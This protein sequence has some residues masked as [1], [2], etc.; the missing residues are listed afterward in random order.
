MVQREKC[1]EQKMQIN[2]LHKPTSQKRRLSSRLFLM[3]VTKLRRRG[4]FI[5]FFL[6]GSEYSRGEPIYISLGLDHGKVRFKNKKKQSTY[7]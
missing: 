3:Y 5:S 7:I 2:E 6:I 4:F 1:I